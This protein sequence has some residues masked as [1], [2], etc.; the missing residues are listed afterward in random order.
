MPLRNI[1]II[2]VTILAAWACYSVAP[3]TRHAG[4]FAEA[5]ELVEK[6]G[7]EEVPRDQLFGSAVDG[8]LNEI[9]EH[10]TYFYGKRYQAV[11]EELQ[12]HFG[13][14][15]MFVGVDPANRELV[16]MAA[17]PNTPAAKAGLQPGDAILAIDGT[18]ML[19]QTRE[20]AIERMRGP[21]GKP[22]TLQIRTQDRLREVTLIRDTINVDSVHG[23]W[24]N[25]DGQ[26]DFF[27]KADPSTGYVR[28][29]QFGDRT[30]EELQSAL[31]AIDGKV[32]RLILDLRM[33]SGG[34]LEAAVGTCDLF[35]PAQKL[36]VET[37]G[38]NPRFDEFHFTQSPPQF[39]PQLP[40]VVLVNRHSA[41]AA[42]IVAACLQDHG[43]ATVIGERSY[44]KGTVQN[45]IPL[46]RNK[47]AVK[48]TTANYL[49]PGNPET[50]PSPESRNMDRGRAERH[51][52][53]H[54]GVLPDPDWALEMTE[55]DIFEQF[56][57]RNA[58]DLAG[59]RN[60]VPAQVP[61][62]DEPSADQTHARDFR[63]QVLDRAL[64][65]FGISPPA[66]ESN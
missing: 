2:A 64:K 15:G 8:M 62:P 4:L 63:D 10:S 18:S 51:G 58:R 25:P 45:V 5:L 55:A 14:V 56:R 41:S 54:W 33:N 29:S 65:F 39:D 36:V 61:Q 48:L 43:R 46:E 27:L 34:L 13:G 37:R 1:V 60:G 47:S 16:V 44:G 53:T 20:T 9:D 11:E 35:L 59:L 7:L 22:V 24:L 52:W 28:I 6:E 17:M 49:R 23:D 57:Q 42:E 19:G 26:W 21:V 12:Q 38:R 50:T 66:S 30:V 32:Q 31:R 40:L 3:K